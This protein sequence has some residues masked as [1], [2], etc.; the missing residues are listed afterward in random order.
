MVTLAQTRSFSALSC[1]V[2]QGGLLWLGWPD[3]T[4]PA[5]HAPD[6]STAHLFTKDL[7]KHRVWKLRLHLGSEHHCLPLPHGPLIWPQLDLEP[8]SV[9]FCSLPGPRAPPCHAPHHHLRR[10]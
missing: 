8:L 2:P 7:S 4:L 6:G 5:A 9:P 10:A 1:S 3:P